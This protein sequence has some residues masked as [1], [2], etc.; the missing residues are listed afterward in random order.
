MIECIPMDISKTSITIREPADLHKALMASPK[1]QAA[2]TGLTS[3]ARRDFI[4]WIESAKQAE[5]HARRI[6]RTCSML[7][8][9]K[10]RPCCYAVVPM[11][12]YKAL[13]GN[14]KAKAFWK[15]LSP[16]E[17]RDYVAWVDAGTKSESRKK[18]ASDVCVMLEA[19]KA[20]P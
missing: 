2:W 9:G 7:V 12:I 17:R 3:I 8:K 4:T 16:D 13:S 6:E 11:D 19:K 14:A 10:R 5:T 1:A 18:R 15:T 20:H